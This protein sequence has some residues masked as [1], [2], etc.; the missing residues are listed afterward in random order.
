VV[1]TTR[2]E[3][4]LGDTAVAVH[5]DDE[6][7]KAMIGKNV[8]HPITGREFP[9]IADSEL[10]DPRF[11]TGAVKVTPAHSFEDFESGK[12]HHLQFINILNP[13]GTLNAN[14]G[15]FQG[16]IASGPAA[17]EGPPGRVGP[18]ARDPAAHPGAGRCQRC[19]SIIE[20]LMSKQWFVKTGPLAEKVIAKVDEM[21][22]VPENWRAEF[23][24]WMNN[25]HDWCISAPALWATRS[26]PGIAST[27]T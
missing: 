12:R 26:R 23:L 10:V 21:R 20:P 4:M 11:G 18:R 17:A 9:I 24:R 2:P 1:A 15:P 6:R 7:Y 8:R 5:P 13:D 14:A 19:G 3:T 22:F 25:I 16:R 27:G